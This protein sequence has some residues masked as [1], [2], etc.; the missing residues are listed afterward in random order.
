M[1]FGSKAN[2]G[3]S[4]HIW[5][6]ISWTSPKTLYFSMHNGSVILDLHISTSSRVYSC[7]VIGTWLKCISVHAKELTQAIFHVLSIIFKLYC[8]LW[9]YVGN[10]NPPVQCPLRL[11]TS[12]TLKAA[13]KA[14]RKMAVGASLSSTMKWWD[15]CICK[16]IHCCFSSMDHYCLGLPGLATNRRPGARRQPSA[17]MWH[18]FVTPL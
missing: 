11:W 1:S 17:T 6:I 12:A 8:A 7:H 10:S 16:N 5:H 9:C 2:S 3:L 14:E 15:L 13:V 4:R 18:H